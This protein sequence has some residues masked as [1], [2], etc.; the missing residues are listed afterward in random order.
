MILASGMPNWIL[1]FLGSGGMFGKADGIW[2]W[3]M[4]IVTL[5]MGQNP[6]DISPEAWSYITDTVYPWF[7]TVGVTLLNLFFMVG[8]LRQSTNLRENLP[9][10]VFVEQIIKVIIANILMLNSITLIR[11]F[12]SGA[13][14][15]A[16]NIMV[17]S[18]PT[19]FGSEVDAGAVLA[20]VLFGVI[21]ILVSAVCGIV[22]L[23]EVLARFLNL[24][25]LTAFAP[26]AFSTLA[27]GRGIE[28]SAYSWI[29]SFLNTTFQIVV[30]ALIIR[31]GSLMI[32]SNVI[33]AGT[34]PFGD[35]WFDGFQDVLL[36]MVTMIFMATAVKTS[37][38]FLKR[39][40]DLR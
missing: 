31:I 11:D 34:L 21:Y 38:A 17:T 18:Y 20:Y 12:I 13:G 39:A 7:L 4:T 28:S 25:L 19:I 22:I 14:L 8:F 5:L 26:V 9:L 24:F 36:S 37:D 15:L 2:G 3:C 10:E 23:I 1:D 35:S 16:G 6:S 29:R 30:I 40:L 27:G 33:S 32:R